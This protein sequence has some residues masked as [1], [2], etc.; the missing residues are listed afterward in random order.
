MTGDQM[1]P[2]IMLWVGELVM[3]LRGLYMVHIEH[4]ARCPQASDLRVRCR[5]SPDVWM[6][7]VSA[8]AQQEPVH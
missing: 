1:A 7:P 3:K 6:E 5:C 4:D 8:K 2:L